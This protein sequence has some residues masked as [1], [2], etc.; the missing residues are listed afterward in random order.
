M[1]KKRAFITFESYGKVPSL[2]ESGKSSSIVV[3]LLLDSG[4]G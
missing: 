3:L 2:A 1:P 4:F